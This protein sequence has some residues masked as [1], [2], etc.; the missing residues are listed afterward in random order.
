MTAF[1]SR[2]AAAVVFGATLT[3]PR[4]AIGLALAFTTI[5]AA[6]RI[7]PS[8]R[9]RRPRTALAPAHAHQ[10]RLQRAAALAGRLAAPSPPQV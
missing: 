9:V 7:F 10:P 5:W 1:V 3:N 4:A 2:F 8:R 6:L